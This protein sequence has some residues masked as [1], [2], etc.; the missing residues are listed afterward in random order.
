MRRATSLVIMAAVLSAAAAAQSPTTGVITGRVV[1]ASGRPIAGA[2][3]TYSKDTEYTRDNDGR[4]VVKELGADGVTTARSDGTFSLPGLQSGRYHI[5]AQGTQ[6]TQ[7]G[8]C[9]WDGLPV[10]VLVPGQ[11]V[12]DVTRTIWDATVLNIR[13]ADPKGIIAGADKHGVVVARD[14]RFAVGVSLENGFFRR[15]NVLS[16]SATQ[17]VFRA[18][19]PRNRPARLFVDSDLRV[20]DGSGRVVETNRPASQSVNTTTDTATI[21]LNV[22]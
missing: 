1:D 8:S 16:E 5:C 15:A 14:R 6:E 4:V 18:R 19:V 21:N 22:S 13:V 7:I 2:K 9:E 20:T 11:T 17:R 12:T 3:V 10:I